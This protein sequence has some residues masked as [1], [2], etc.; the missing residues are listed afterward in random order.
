M[1][2][3]RVQGLCERAL[4]EA[5][6]NAEL[7]AS[8]REHLSWVGIYRGD[9]ALASAL[10]AA[11]MDSLRHVTDRTIAGEVTSTFAMVQ[12]LLGKPAQDL[13]TEAE[14]L[15]DL[16][17]QDKP[18]AEMTNHTEAR[19]G[20]GLQL[21]WAGDLDAAR[22]TLT[23]ALN[24]YE[25]H[26][27]YV[28]R[29]EILNYLAK[30]EARAGNWDVAAAH[31]AEAYEID[32]ESGRLSGQGH[33]LFPVALVAALKGEV[34]KARSA[35][36]RGLSQCLANGDLLDVGCH[37]WVLGFLE[38]SLS[39]PSAAMQHFGPAIEYLHALGSPE[40]AIIPCVPDA[41]EAL[42]ALGDLGHANA[43]LQEHDRKARTQHRPW[44]LAT[45]ARCRGL[46]AAAGGDLLEAIR[47]LDQ[48][49]GHH[50]DL[51]QPFDLGRTLLVAGDVNRRAKRKQAARLAFHHALELFEQV[52][53]PLWIEK[54]EAGLSRTGVRAA[55]P[56][57]L[58]P[59]ERRIADLVAEGRTN[60][61]VADALFVS[62]KTVEAN[63][64]RV[65]H[66]LGVRSRT[67]LTRRIVD[68]GNQ[69]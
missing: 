33:M 45:A 56:T 26:G 55:G 19:V 8:I 38:L 17:S 27:R 69:P 44:A 65:Y 46:V 29:D 53:A 64:S 9:M 48:A 28:V 13:M 39:H 68:P 43:L 37:R 58:S 24:E 42:V 34:K 22:Q 57:G 20:H 2:M 41:I 40:P 14:R 5:G 25:K 50:E 52:G 35:G 59:T 30:V 66:K 51:S 54:A 1:D 47:A 60:R 18:A 67:E 6:D 63:L 32:V 23:W 3:H 7:L 4:T 31:A 36:E 49:L 62:M 16:A 15:A 10:A 11:A 61:E 21:L 12:F